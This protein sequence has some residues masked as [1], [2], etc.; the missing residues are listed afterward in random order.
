MEDREALTNPNRPQ[1]APAG[2]DRKLPSRE[3]WKEQHYH[4]GKIRK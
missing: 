4:P 1:P 2:I 3:E